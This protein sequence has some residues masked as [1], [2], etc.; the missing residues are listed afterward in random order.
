MRRICGLLIMLTLFLLPRLRGQQVLI[1]DR[2]GIYNI[3]RSAEWL[4]DSQLNLTISEVAVS[5]QFH[6]L[7]D[8][9]EIVNFGTC[10]AAIWC[11]LSWKA[12]VE[13][14]LQISIEN[15][16][17]DSIQV[18][19]GHNGKFW[20]QRAGHKI[21]TW[22]SLPGLPGYVY[23]IPGNH[24][25]QELWIRFKTRNTLV[26]P[27]FIGTQVA[28]EKRVN[29]QLLSDGVSAGVLVALFLY[30]LMLWLVIRRRTYFFYVVFLLFSASYIMLYLKGFSHFFSR[31]VIDFFASYGFG[32][33]NLGYLF[34]VVFATDFLKSSLDKSLYRFSLL[35]Q[36]VTAGFALSA[37]AG[38]YMVAL[39]G[40]Q[41]LI[42]LN[43]ACIL[44]MA[45]NGVR[46]GVRSAKFLLAA[47]LVFLCIM[48]LH[49]MAI[50]GM[51]P[52]NSLM[53][54]LPDIG[55]SLELIWLSFF[56][57]YSYNLLKNEKL[58]LQQQALQLVNDRKRQLVDLVQTRTKE[59][60][61][62][63]NIKDKVLASISHD[64]RMPLVNT[65]GIFEL[66]DGGLLSPQESRI[67]LSQL[68]NTV[69]EIAGTMGNL[70]RWSSGSRFAASLSSQVVNLSAAISETLK[71]YEA[72]CIQKGIRLT[73]SCASQY[74][75]IDP[76]QL[77]LILRNLIDNAIKH[78]YLGGH[79][80][81]SCIGAGEEVTLEISN[82]IDSDK[83]K[84]IDKEN[85]NSRVRSDHSLFNDCDNG[86]GLSLCREFL[87][88]NN[89]KLELDI[90][91]DLWVS[92]FQL[93]ATIE[94]VLFPALD[95]S[96]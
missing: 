89:S 84:M 94:P 78:N 87:E 73:L 62:R 27:I 52:F 72:S 47:W 16:N 20:E 22:H 25:A 92:S 37:F 68:R 35:L 56:L 17:I 11:H 4:V 91:N 8:K 3:G 90:R 46:Y 23:N 33:C 79:V 31:S 10:D 63:N 70:I 95:E 64:L 69:A 77:K 5:K 13:G 28:M 80:N 24:S 48:M 9:T 42:F 59:L 85:I 58:A 34:A 43:V 32:I 30:N 75:I 71:L 82:S 86:L 6:S 51:I 7:P 1:N 50:L 18:F 39:K 74:V 96:Q 40:S 29:S 21:E 41:Y 26:L 36:L 19:G 54:R 88:I 61:E 65:L 45:W 76:D 66:I 55:L 44:V 60:S 81:I 12:Q 57:G 14:Q 83:C 53:L 67:K 2:N 38:Y 93:K 49:A 15:A